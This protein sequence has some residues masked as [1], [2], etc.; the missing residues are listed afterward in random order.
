MLF[1]STAQRSVPLDLTLAIL[2]LIS[3]EPSESSKPDRHLQCPA[4]W[5]SQSGPII[6]RW[7]SSG[8]TSYPELDDS[9]R[10]DHSFEQED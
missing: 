6:D 4:I 2:L 3:N 8:Q 1:D 5:L 10:R 9:G 7:A